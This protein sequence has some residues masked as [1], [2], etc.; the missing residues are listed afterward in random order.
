MKIYNKIVLNIFTG[1]T[2]Y[3]DSFEYEGEVAH[4]GK[5]GGGGDSGDQ[6]VTMRYAPYIEVRHQNFLDTVAAHRDYLIGSA[7][8]VS[9]IGDDVGPVLG[10][11]MKLLIDRAGAAGIPLSDAITHDSPFIAYDNILID[12]AFFGTGYTIASFPSLYDMYG[13]FMAGLDIDTL[14]SQVFE[15]TVN[16]PEINNLVAAE[17]ALLDDEITEKVLPPILT[18]ARDINSVLSST[19]VIAKAIPRDTQL[20]LIEKFSSEAKYRMIPVAVDRWKTHLE[21]N[22]AVV[23]SYAEIMKLY[24]SSKM[25]VTDFNY[26]MLAKDKLWPFTVLDY[27]RAALGALQ[28]ATT[29]NKDVAGGSTMQ[30]AIGGAMSGAAMGGM[31]GSMIAGSTAGSTMGLPGAIVGGVLGLA[32]SL[33]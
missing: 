10:S 32:G 2:V 19:F 22:K 12:V 11:V 25:D 23:M 6:V 7:N 13:K 14:F 8:S 9:L 28:G 16:A 27:E 30:K 26:S 29:T 20:K 24:F 21:W 5:S 15:D 18:G 31:V 33:F 3:E 17:S 1:E 4:C